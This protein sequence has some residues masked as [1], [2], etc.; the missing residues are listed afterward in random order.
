MAQNVVEIYNLA[1]SAVGT[2]ARIEAETEDSR[3]GQICRLWYP[4]VRDIALR[5]SHWSSC[6]ASSLLVLDASASVNADWAEGDPEPPWTYRYSLPNGFLYPRYLDTYANF[7]LTTYNN[8]PMLLTNSE[9]PVLTYTK[10]T[11]LPAM[12][13][14]DLYNSIVMALAAAICVPLAGKVDRARN[15]LQ[16]A[17]RAVLNARV[18]NGNTNSMQ[19]DSMPDWLIA[20]GAGQMSSYSQYIYQYGPLFSGGLFL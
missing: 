13:D 3:E 18:Q 14:V 20:R 4:T 2:R 10:R 17:D 12:W 16:E 19:Q 11:E 7:E 9:M 15:L 1:L 6:R 8:A 5:A